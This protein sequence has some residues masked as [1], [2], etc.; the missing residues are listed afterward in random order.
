MARRRGALDRRLLD[1]RSVTGEVLVAV[2]KEHDCS[3]SECPACGYVPT[4]RQR[5]CRSVTVAQGLVCGRAPRWTGDEPAEVSGEG[6]TGGGGGR[7]ELF[8]TAGLGGPG[9]GRRGSGRGRA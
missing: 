4:R 1:G 3:R 6:A 2:L 8:S 5:V 7:Y 9:D